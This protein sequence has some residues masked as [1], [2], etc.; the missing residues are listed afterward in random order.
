MIGLLWA[1]LGVAVM[2]LA[3]ILWIAIELDAFVH[4]WKDEVPCIEEVPGNDELDDITVEEDDR[5]K[6]TFLRDAE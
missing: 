5:G 3:G 4:T 2:C 6:S 1:I